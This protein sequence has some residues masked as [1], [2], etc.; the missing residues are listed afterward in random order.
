MSSVQRGEAGVCVFWGFG[1]EGEGDFGRRRSQIDKRA[2]LHVC[3]FSFG[4]RL[5]DLPPP[6]KGNFEL[7]P[8]ATVLL[9]VFTQ[10]LQ[11]V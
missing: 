5:P 6:Q 7:R 4:P 1:G 2:V 11:V 10:V 8:S 3:F 9:K